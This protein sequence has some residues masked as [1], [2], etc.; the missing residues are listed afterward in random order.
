[1]GYGEGEMYFGSDSLALAPLTRRIA[2]LRDGDWA[3]L[4]RESAR[5]FDTTGA[6]VQREAKLVAPGAASVGKE[7]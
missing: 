4:S 5:F 2:F 1:M 3:V 6:E 7:E